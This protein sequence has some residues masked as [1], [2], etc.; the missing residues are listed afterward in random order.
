MRGVW[1][2]WGEGPC[3]HPPPR[4]TEGSRSQGS[5]VTGAGA[6][7]YA[8]PAV[9]LKGLESLGRVPLSMPTPP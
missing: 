4:E 1:S 5:G 3:P 9:R 2:H 6:P 7:V 8:H